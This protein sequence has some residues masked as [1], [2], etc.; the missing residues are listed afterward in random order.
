MPFSLKEIGFDEVLTLM[1]TLRDPGALFEANHGGKKECSND[2]DE[3]QMSGIM[4]DR[5]DA[6]SLVTEEEA[7]VSLKDCL[8]TVPSIYFEKN[9][10]LEEQPFMHNESAGENAVEE[11]K[12]QAKKLLQEKLTRHLDMVEANLLNQVSIKSKSFFEALFSVQVPFPRVAFNPLFIYLKPLACLLQF[13]HRFFDLLCP[14]IRNC[15]AR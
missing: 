6:A 13:T 9:Y 15:S 2:S 11:E 5:M 7:A 14:F 1:T 3:E 10:K 8:E 12:L 4:I